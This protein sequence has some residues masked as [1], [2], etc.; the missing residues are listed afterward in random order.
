MYI[1]KMNA[2]GELKAIEKEGNERTVGVLYYHK[3][4]QQH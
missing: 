2:L 4:T 1:L 3:E